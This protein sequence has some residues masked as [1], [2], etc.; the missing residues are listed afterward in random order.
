MKPSNLITKLVL[1]H[2]ASMLQNPKNC[3][4]EDYLGIIQSVIKWSVCC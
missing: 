4:F 2:W 3:G 1:C